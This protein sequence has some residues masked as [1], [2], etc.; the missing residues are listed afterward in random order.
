MHFPKRALGKKSGARFCFPPHY[1]GSGV[2]R[3]LPL[4]ASRLTFLLLSVFV[5]S[6]CV[7]REPPADVTVINGTEP[8]SLDPHIVTGIP[9]MRLV[10]ALFD[11][12][13]KLD[14]REARP[15]PAL[16]ERWD[17]SP[18]GRVYTFHLRPHAVWSTGDPITSADVLWSWMRA[19][20]PATAG[21]Y[22][23]QLFY[24]KGA[25]DWYNGKSQDSSQV[26][27]RALDA[28]T[29]R[30]ELNAPLAFFPD[31]C[32]FPT[33]AV[34]PRATI[35]KHG[36]RWL[37]ARPLPTSGAFTLGAWRVNDKVRLIR[38]PRY[39]D[40]AHT[41]S[42]I[43]DVLPTGS[44]NTALNL[45][46]TGVADIVW[47]KDL[48]PAELIEVLKQR[49]DFHSFDYLGT[50]FY[51]FNV[52]Q[53]P[54]NDARVRRA[55]AMVTDKSRI[56]TKLT[57]GGEKPARHFVPEGVANYAAPP[58]LPFD[59]EQAREL[60][61]EAGFPGGQGFPRT[62]YTFP[63][64]AA[65]GAKMPGKIAVELQ[66][67]WRDALGIQIE[68]RQ[69]ERKIFY[70]SQSRLDYDLS[71]SSWVG[72]YNDANTFLDLFT[73]ASGNNRTG[74]KNARYDELIRDANLQTDLKRRAEIFRLAE[75][76]LVREEAP[77]VPL[78]FYAGFN[79]YPPE[80]IGGVW[81]NILDEHPLQYIYKKNR[82]SRV[83]GRGPDA[84]GV[85]NHQQH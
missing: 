82:G 68:L 73:G 23:S 32:A 67:M 18:D 45:Y 13:V 33:L 14:P 77:V 12:L 44:P 22:A 75:E 49:P 19:L 64:A 1:A 53:P 34:V 62:T 78:Y 59:V 46:E 85:G 7:H 60:L 79:Y 43:I 80:R 15:V 63:A 81:P 72:D 6:A 52:T 5:L 56:T 17:V 54:F 25:E 39:W 41:A 55:F 51:R 42:E 47:D 84:Q 74:W 50:Y 36:D 40:A 9:E 83:E 48:V 35:E 26:G 10:K 69:L 21:D 24:I 4:S 61:A 66:Q 71:A 28:H 27:L 30:V 29:L 8:E 70:S 58:G 38:N 31:L 76:I 57:K 16:A 65:G 3:R 2:T 20:S 37:H 11:G